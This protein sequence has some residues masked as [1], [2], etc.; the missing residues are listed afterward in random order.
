[1]EPQREGVGGDPKIPETT[2]LGFLR[3][4]WDHTV[5]PRGRTIARMPALVASGSVDHAL[6][7]SANSGLIGGE[8][9]PTAP[10]SAALFAK[11]TVFVGF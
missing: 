4:S 7:T 10:D 3:R 11:W 6:I 9:A 1:M 8:S 2:P 5:S